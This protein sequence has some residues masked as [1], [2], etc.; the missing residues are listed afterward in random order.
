MPILLLI[1]IYLAFISLGLPDSL[2]GVSWPLVYKEFHVPYEAAGWISIT[3]TICTTISA[4]MSGNLNRRLGTS[5]IVL[6]SGAMTAFALLGFSFSHSIYFSILMAIPLGLGAGSVD[7]SLNNYV[8]LHY[9]A[10]HMSWLH[11]FW[12]V[13][14]TLGP[15]IMAAYIRESGS[16][17]S[18]YMTI[19]LIQ[20]SLAVILLLSLPLWN[21]VDR[22]RTKTESPHESN[23][24]MAKPLP[25][26][27]ILKLKGV[28]YALGVFL[29]YCGIEASM[30]LW[31]SSF[32]IEIK[33][34]TPAT[35]A[36]LVSLYFG[37]ITVGRM[38]SGFITM[39]LSNKEMI[40]LG[41]ALTVIGIIIILLP[42]PSIGSIVGFLMVGIGLAPIFP[43]MIHETPSRFGKLH[44]QQIIGFQMAAAYTGVTVLPPLLGVLATRTT[45]KLIPISL[46]GF[47]FFMI[48]ASESVNKIVAK[49][50][51]Q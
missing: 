26:F 18:G 7:A 35:A 29:F 38:V 51:V 13:G 43:C 34:L 23:E 48:I 1:I 47:V 12:G 24:H 15:I 16:W 40:R 41:Q 3:I 31:G 50:Q 4:L 42:L 22:L 20:C 10:H 44:S 2:L 49:A 6:I 46:L 17:R 8:A 25:A 28:L 19:G 11:S 27:E 37:G 36:S 5:K 9:K 33:G 45:M 32:L 39:K 21:K 14:A 30:G